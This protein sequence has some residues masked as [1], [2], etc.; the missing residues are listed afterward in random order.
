MRS[1]KWSTSETVWIEEI[2]DQHKEIF[3]RVDRL[4][5]VLSNSGPV[6]D[7]RKS[8]E[9]LATAITGHFAHEERLMRASRYGSLRWHKG[10]HEAAGR[11]VQRYT[12]AIDRGDREAGRALVEYLTEWL[13]DHTRV[14]DRMMSAHL[15]NQSLSVGKLVFRAGTKAAGACTWVDSTGDAF[16]PMTSTKGL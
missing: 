15:R 8:L 6:A 9:R 10:L 11:N 1:I 7:I 14:A 3:A 16:D 13:R 4:Q 12:R 5:R 2:D